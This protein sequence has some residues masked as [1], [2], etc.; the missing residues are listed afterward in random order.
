MSDFIQIVRIT[1]PISSWISSAF[2]GIRGQAHRLLP[3]VI[4]SRRNLCAVCGQLPSAL[5][6]V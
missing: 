5:P 2:T 4:S 6:M 1:V 3:L